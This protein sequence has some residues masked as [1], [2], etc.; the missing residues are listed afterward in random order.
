MITQNACPSCHQELPSEAKFCFSCGAK[1]DAKLSC[2]HCSAELIPG[3]KFCGE[4]GKSI[5]DQDG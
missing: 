3:S 1:L 5:T 4:C 2:P